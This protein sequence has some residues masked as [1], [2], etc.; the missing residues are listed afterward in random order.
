[1]YFSVIRM[2]ILC[3]FPPCEFVPWVFL[4]KFFFAQNLDFTSIFLPRNNPIWCEF[5]EENV[6]F[7]RCFFHAFY[8]A[9]SCGNELLL[10]QSLFSW[11]L[12]GFVNKTKL[13][14]N[15]L[16][17]LPFYNHEEN[18]RVDYL[19]WA[20]KDRQ[21][22]ILRRIGPTVRLPFM[23]TTPE[24]SGDSKHLESRVF[25]QRSLPRSALTLVLWAFIQG[26]PGPSKVEDWILKKRVI[27]TLFSS[28]FPQKSP[29]VNR[30]ILRSLLLTQEL[31]FENRWVHWDRVLQSA[32]GFAL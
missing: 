26:L 17:F 25:I 24:D 30:S 20:I 22:R 2:R 6:L 5:F 12:L 19:L 9:F 7:F 23:W 28:L 13:W 27:S 32:F 31:A 16:S 4:L 21:T 15:L 29:L 18:D 8:V 14:L 1:M 11:V 3:S 10:L